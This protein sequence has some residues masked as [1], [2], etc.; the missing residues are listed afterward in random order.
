M[1]ENKELNA[2]QEND[3]QNT[4]PVEEPEIAESVEAVATEAVVAEEIADAAE[5]PAEEIPAEEVAEPA[6]EDA[7][8]E[9]TPAE[10]VPAEEAEAAAAVLA[11]V[12]VEPAIPEEEQPKPAPKKMKKSLKVTLI[13]LLVILLL[14]LGIVGLAY[15]YY[16]DKIGQLRPDETRD[17]NETLSSSEWDDMNSSNEMEDIIGTLPTLKPTFP[18]YGGD[19]DRPDYLDDVTNILL[20]GTDERT[21]EFTHKAR[22]DSCMLLSINT[23]GDA[24]VISLISF[25]R[26]M[27]MPIL[28]GK[29]AGQWDW[30]T[31][32]FRYG[33]AEMMMESIE[34]CFDIEIDYY[35]RTNFACFREGIDALGGV[36]IKF[37]TREA[38]FFQETFKVDAVKGMNHLDGKNALRYARLRVI[39]S[40]W[41]RVER[42]RKVIS[43]VITKLKGKSFSEL[44]ALID[45]ATGL[46]RTNLTEDAITKLLLDVV[47]GLSK[48]T[49]QQMTIPQKGTYGSHKVMGDRSAYAPDFE[50][51]TRLLH[52]MI[53]GI[54]E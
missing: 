20:I 46:V 53:Y 8:V 41:K 7:S 49:V 39:D 34:A 47:P 23:A 26:A 19:G 37:T 14:L 1:E 38:E 36:D 2:P 29:Y 6:Q 11:D 9:E 48:V 51:N 44:D 40:D 45:V 24:P 12:E 25:E 10:E 33:G 4:Q 54:S 16:R 18:S 30:L 35:V 52:E 17:P 31:H 43:A 5:A 32:L 15:G 27:G 22:G 42:Q 13:I 28:S 21:S 3:A 50:E